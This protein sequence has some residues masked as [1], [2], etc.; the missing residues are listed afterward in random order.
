MKVSLKW[1]KEYV[2]ITLPVNDLVNRLTMAGMEVSEI[3]AVGDS[4]ER[5]VIG[6]IIAINPH[7]NADRLCLATV[8]L[9]TE[10]QTIVTGAPNLKVGDKVPFAH[11][12]AKLIDGHSGQAFRLKSAKLRGVESNGMVCSEK[13]LNISDNHEGIMVLPS[14]APIGIPLS[15]YLG[16][17]IFNL[18]ITPNRAD[19]L[20]V[21]GIA[22]EVSALTGQGFHSAEVIYEETTLPIEQQVSVEIAAPE[23]CPRYCASL[24]TGVKLASSPGWMQQRLLACGMRPINNIVDITNYVMLEHGQP[25]HAFDYDQIRGKR[26]IVRRAYNDETIVTLD[27]VERNLSEDM[28]VIADEKRAVAIA[29][30]MGGID[31]EVSEQTTSIL[32]ESANFNPASNHHTSSSLHMMSE[33]SL[34][35]GRGISP[36]LTLPAL[37]RATQLIAELAGGTVAK[38]IIDVYPI[39]LKQDPILLSTNRTSSLL[40]VDLTIDQ[41]TGALSSL[42]FECQRT[43]S[44]SEVR[45]TTPYWRMDIHLPVD[46]IEE[47]ARII[48][49]DLIPMTMLSEPLPEHSTEPL[50]GLKQEIARSLACY[51][52]QEIITYSLISLEML[53]KLSPQHHEHK[54]M[55]IRLANPMSAEQEYLRPNLRANLLTALVE[56]R[57]HEEGGIRLFELGRIYLSRAGNLPDEREVVCGLLSGARS[58]KSWLGGD[59]LIDFYDVKGVVEGLLDRLGLEASFEECLDESLHPGKQAA[60]VIKGN[61]VGVLGELHPHV[62]RAF[63]IYEPV[64]LFELDITSLSPLIT[65]HKVYQPIPRFPSVTR[66]IAIVLDAG[67]SHAKVQD[68]IASFPLVEQVTIFDVY[69]GEQVPQGKKSLAYRI[70][71]LSPDHTLTDEEVNKVQEQIISKLSNEFG[72]TLRS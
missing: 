30:I 12:G 71:F 46:L 64:Y 18:E 1:L 20:S 5:I 69:A 22:R 9:G 33:A 29:G 57:K 15:D 60:V 72:A 55:P 16:D 2:D 66:D 54:P 25:L 62:S 6:Q 28:L 59:G 44:I 34:R 65:T 38:G 10:Q 47:V 56:N 31:S 4:W 19:C 58:E 61:K 40:G 13:E 68:I 8:D 49:Y 42:G 63:E 70:T 37:K 45:V 35:F 53:N 21:I 24:I 26:I 43:G 36:E 17:I 7:P 23:L 41:I 48:G 67:V 27:G 11:I 14:D 3:Q 32:L 50:V 39:R 52:F 51:G